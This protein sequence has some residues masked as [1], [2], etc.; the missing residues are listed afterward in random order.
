MVLSTTKIFFLLLE[1]Y[2]SMA[3][4]NHREK[5]ADQFICLIL[6]KSHILGFSPDMFSVSKKF[7]FE[8]ELELTKLFGVA[9]NLRSHIIKA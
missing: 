5:L 7:D 4:R 1:F 2:N 3:Q 8:N 6:L 9:I